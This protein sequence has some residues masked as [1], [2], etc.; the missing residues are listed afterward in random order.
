VKSYS[1]SINT[2]INT[3]EKKKLTSRPTKSSDMIIIIKTQLR[4]GES[5]INGLWFKLEMVWQSAS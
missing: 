1:F 4:R 3:R 5:A 2:S